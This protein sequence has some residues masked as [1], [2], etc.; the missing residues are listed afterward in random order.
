LGSQPVIG[1]AL[2]PF[3]NEKL[4]LLLIDIVFGVYPYRFN[5]FEKTF[6]NSIVPAISF[7]DYATGYQFICAVLR[8]F[9]SA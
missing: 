6:S 2:N 5:G 8:M 3:K 1:P 9:T 4:C 7:P